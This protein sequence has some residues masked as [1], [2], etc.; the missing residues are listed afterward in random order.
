M[1]D[2]LDSPFTGTAQ[3]VMPAEQATEDAV[4]HKHPLLFRLGSG[5]LLRL[6]VLTFGADDTF[7]IKEL[8]E[9]SGVDFGTILSRNRTLAHPC[10]KRGI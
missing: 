8:A 1:L 6:A 7:E 3:T 10:E 5:G 4:I 2:A 9:K